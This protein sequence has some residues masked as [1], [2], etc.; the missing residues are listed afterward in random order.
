MLK[1]NDCN[2]KSQQDSPNSNELSEKMTFVF[3]DGSR[4]VSKLLSVSWEVSF[5][6]GTT[7]STEWLNLVPRLSIGDCFEIH[8]PYWLIGNF[9]ISCV[10]AGALPAREPS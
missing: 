6:T 2:D 9:V 4:N 7:E 3:F 8:L 1:Y 10:S 5:C